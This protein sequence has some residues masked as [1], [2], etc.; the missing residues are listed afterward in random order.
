MIFI[1]I[2]IIPAKNQLEGYLSKSLEKMEYIP[3]IGEQVYVTENLQLKVESVNYSGNSLNIIGVTL[4]AV[5]MS[6]DEIKQLER[7][8]TDKKTSKWTYLLKRT[9]A[10]PD[11]GMW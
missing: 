5:S 9:M 8:V 6:E 10:D 1:R 3:R 2:P 11:R 7:R 4:E